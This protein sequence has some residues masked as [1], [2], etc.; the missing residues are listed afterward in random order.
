MVCGSL[1]CF[2]T[3]AALAAEEHL[4]EMFSPPLSPGVSALHVCKGSSHA[5]PSSHSWDSR[6]TARISS[7]VVELG[8]FRGFPGLWLPE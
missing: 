5:E 2:N 8:P 1:S 4:Y 3:F 7:G 6:A